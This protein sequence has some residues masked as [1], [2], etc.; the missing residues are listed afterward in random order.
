MNCAGCTCRIGRDVRDGSAE[1]FSGLKL[2][3]YQL[4]SIVH[5]MHEHYIDLNR[6]I[7]EE[8]KE[9]KKRLAVEQV[10][11]L[12]T[13]TTLE[14]QLVQVIKE[15]EMLKAQL[16]C[17]QMRRAATLNVVAQGEPSQDMDVL[18]GPDHH[19]RKRKRLSIEGGDRKRKRRKYKNVT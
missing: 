11:R 14:D 3:N 17:V 8:L 10:K 18:G 1:H 7:G 5:T 4:L 6:S 9:E 16:S 13:T 15:N 19:A 2:G 12:E